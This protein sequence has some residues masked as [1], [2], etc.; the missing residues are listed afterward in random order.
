MKA[1]LSNRASALI[2]IERFFSHLT[3]VSKVVVPALP[4]GRYRFICTPHMSGGMR[5]ELFV[6]P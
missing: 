2:M 6:V 1:L 3:S 5:G 4:P